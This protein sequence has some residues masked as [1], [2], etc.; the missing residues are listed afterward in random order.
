MTMS[1]LGWMVWGQGCIG[2]ADRRRRGGGGY[3]LPLDLDFTGG[4]G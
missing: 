2:T 3:P 1:E 4:G